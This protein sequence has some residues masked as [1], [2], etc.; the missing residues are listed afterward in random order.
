MQNS[1]SSRKRAQ[2]RDRAVV[3]AIASSLATVI[4]TSSSQASAACYP[5]TDLNPLE[6]SLVIETTGGSYWDAFRSAVVEPFEQACDVKVTMAISPQRNI[7]QLEGL[8]KRKAVTWD[9]GIINNPWDYATALRED[10][11]E[12]FPKDFWKPIEAKLIPGAYSDYSVWSNI[13]GVHLVYNTDTFAQKP[14]NWKDFWD[15]AKFPGPRSMQD[16]VINVV[17]ALLA[18]GVAPKEI[19]PITDEKLKRAFVKLDELRPSIRSFWTAGD[20]PIQG[21][22]RGDFVMATGQTSRIFSGLRSGYKIGTT[23]NQA[24]TT[25]SLL[26]RPR[27]AQNPLAAA[28]LLFFYNSEKPQAKMAELT[29]YTGALKNP[30]TFVAPS[31]AANLLTAQD[32]LAQ[33]VP[34]DK[35]WWGANAARIQ[36]LWREWIT[37][38]RVSLSGK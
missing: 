37:T 11:I 3:S 7:G 5:G 28:A 33:T 17:I 32:N 29:G 38:G 25:E 6:S 13:Y 36:P 12:P 35:D 16:N 26:Y 10:L 22:G 2:N 1:S 15:T 4:F 24:I 27:G 30:T 34:L 19:Y 23:F 8:V 9:I 21:V 20:Q 14:E 31:D 18:D